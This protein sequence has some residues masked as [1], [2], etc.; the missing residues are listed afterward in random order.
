MEVI[1]RDALI[2]A[3]IAEVGDVGLTDVTVGRI[4]RR[5]GVSSALAHHYFGSK[6][7]ILLAAMRRILSDYKA[8]V[9]IRFARAET[10]MARLHAIIEASFGDDQF[11]TCIVGAWLEFYVAAHR[12]PAA[13]RILAV[14]ARRLDS[15][16]VHALRQLVDLAAA[17]RIAQGLASMIDGLYLRAALQDHA[18]DAAGSVALVSDYLAIML[19][20]EARCAA[21]TS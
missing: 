4:A 19:E 6:D 10:P 20:N 21:R 8:S 7:E 9:C 17:R 11:D 3:A 5:A 2:R 1:R 18:P 14:Y 15:N 16:L 13:R 12:S